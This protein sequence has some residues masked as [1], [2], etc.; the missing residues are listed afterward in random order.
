MAEPCASQPLEC[1]A[2]DS[3]SENEQPEKPEV[4][5]TGIV[6]TQ[7]D[8][9]ADPERFIESVGVDAANFLPDLD[10]PEVVKFHMRPFLECLESYLDRMSKESDQAENI[11]LAKKIDKEADMAWKVRQVI[12]DCSQQ[13]SCEFYMLCFIECELPSQC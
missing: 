10:K 2:A 9:E 13:F 3:E 5:A 12:L 11:K 4:E 1:E 8:E 6:N 7:V